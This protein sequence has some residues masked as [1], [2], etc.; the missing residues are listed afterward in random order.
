MRRILSAFLKASGVT[1]AVIVALA[2]FD[3]IVIQGIGRPIRWEIPAG[4]QGW[5]VVQYGNPACPPLTEDGLYVV[6]TIPVSGHAC[7]S[8]P[9]PTG[10]SSYR[11]EYVSTDGTR[12][13]V[14]TSGHGGGGEI[15]AGSYT[16]RQAQVPFPEIHF[17]VGSE[18]AL[19]RSWG[20]EPR[21]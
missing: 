10:W 8:T 15:W 4:Y 16:P 3:L 2:V 11:Y 18:A 7:T 13:E 19:Q 5:V 9:P 21:P 14:P 6:V 12:R 1:I 17:F 20:T